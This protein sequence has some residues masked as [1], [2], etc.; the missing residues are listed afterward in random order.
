MTYGGQKV[1]LFSLPIYNELKYNMFKVC[2]VLDP[3]CHTSH[4][5]K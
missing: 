1:Y 3:C 2:S 5:I 4:L